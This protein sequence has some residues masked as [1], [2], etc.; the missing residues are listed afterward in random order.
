MR[1]DCGHP[2]CV[3][4]VECLK[5]QGEQEIKMMLAQPDTFMAKG[6]AIHLSSSEWY[7]DSDS[8][9][10]WKPHCSACNKLRCPQCVPQTFESVSGLKDSLTFENVIQRLCLPCPH[11]ECRGGKVKVICRCEACAHAAC[12]K[13]LVDKPMCHMCGEKN[14]V[15]LGEEESEKTVGGHLRTESTH[16]V[17]TLSLVE[18]EAQSQAHRSFVT[19]RGEAW[20]VGEHQIV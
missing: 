10:A 9:W 6:N 12:E 15:V 5:E 8:G 3:G 17:S 1:N 2:V 4:L 14:M 16:S 20:L 7:W 18:A 19:M 13:C 11:G